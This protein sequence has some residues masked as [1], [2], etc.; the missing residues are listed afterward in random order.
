[1]QAIQKAAAVVAGGLEQ[2]NASTPS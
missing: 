2:A 1:M